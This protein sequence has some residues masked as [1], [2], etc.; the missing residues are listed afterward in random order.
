[1]LSFADIDFTVGAVNPSGISG[2]VFFVPKADITAW[3]TIVDSLESA[4]DVEDYSCYD[5]DFTLAAGK[6]WLKLYNTQGKG[7]LTWDYNGETDCKTVVN[8]ASFSYPK[9][10]KEARAFAKYASNGDFVFVAKH[11]GKYYVI[12]SKDYRATVTPNGDTGDSA[13]SAKGIAIEIECPDVTPLPEYSGKLVL[14][15]G[16]LDCATDIFTATPSG[17]G[18]VTQ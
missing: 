3:P 5:G 14:T 7:K 13:G 4:T 6:K 9:L 15:G 12:G 17:N 2:A 1:M 11:D 8:K 16:T 10:T 18:G